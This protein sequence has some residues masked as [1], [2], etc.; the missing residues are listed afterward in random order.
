MW[1][2]RPNT[3]PHRAYTSFQYLD[4]RQLSIPVVRPM[5]GKQVERH[6]A[7]S[8]GRG[9]D[10]DF[11]TIKFNRTGVIGSTTD[12]CFTSEWCFFDGEKIDTSG[13]NKI[14]AFVNVYIAEKGERRPG[15]IPIDISESD[16]GE[17][18]LEELQQPMEILVSPVWQRRVVPA[19]DDLYASK[20]TP[21]IEHVE[22]Q[23]R[24]LSLVEPD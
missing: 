4:G 1:I 2:V 22:L 11:R 13:T 17:L 3:I 9:L 7:S 14:Y 8:G 19:I 21:W 24:V 12:H 5:G 10:A 6:G 15:L 16:L 23:S 20:V 18:R